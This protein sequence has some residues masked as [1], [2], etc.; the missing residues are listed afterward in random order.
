MFQ[1]KHHVTLGGRHYLPGEMIEGKVPEWWLSVGAA[2]QVD[3]EP[4]SGTTPLSGGQDDTDQT[5]QGQESEETDQSQESEETDQSQE[6]EET[7]QGQESEE[8]DQTDQSDQE[9]E[10]DQE[11]APL[12]INVSAG[13]IPPPE[14]EKPEKPEKPSRTRRNGGK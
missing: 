3:D 8:T 5:D 9:E 12:E 11:A 14:Q 13:I 2:V 1:A 6:S 7:D 10:F 4:E